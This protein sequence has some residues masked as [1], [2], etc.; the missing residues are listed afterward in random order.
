MIDDEYHNF[1]ANNLHLRVQIKNEVV[2]ILTTRIAPLTSWLM[3]NTTTALQVTYILEYRLKRIIWNQ[4]QI[5]DERDLVQP[6]LAMAT[7]TATYIKQGRKKENTE[8][9]SRLM[10]LTNARVGHNQI[11]NTGRSN[12]WKLANLRY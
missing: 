4:C 12:K 7:V 6:S 2:L 10:D 5:D 9:T 11:S 1:I 8:P 3:T